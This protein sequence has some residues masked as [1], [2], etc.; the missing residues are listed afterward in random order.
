MSDPTKNVAVF[1]VD[2][3]GPIIRQKGLP[4]EGAVEALRRLSVTRFGPRIHLI[5]QCDEETERK[6]LEWLRSREFFS[7]S[8]VLPEHVHFCRELWQKAEICVQL[9]VTHFVENRIPAIQRVNTVPNL[10]L[11]HPDPLECEQNPEFMKYVFDPDAHDASETYARPIWLVREWT[12]A[13]VRQIAEAK[14]FR[15]VPRQLRPP[16]MRLG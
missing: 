5:S 3:G 2:L 16:P 13:A 1:A 10:Y 9:G 14:I 8:G 11:F 15:Y 7:R 4:T 12:D 6:R